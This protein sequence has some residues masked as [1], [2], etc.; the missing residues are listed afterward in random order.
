MDMLHTL[1]LYY[2]LIINPLTFAIYGVDKWKA[3]HGKHRIDEST[4]L[5]LAAVGGSIGAWAAMY[6][7]RHKTQHKQFTIGIPAILALQLSLCFALHG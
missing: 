1:L 5:M 4:L 2:L 7:W 6:T 3:R